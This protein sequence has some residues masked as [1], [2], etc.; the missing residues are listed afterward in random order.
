MLTVM[1]RV[2]RFQRRPDV[3]K[4]PKQGKGEKMRPVSIT[5]VAEFP[6]MCEALRAVVRHRQDFTVDEWALVG[7]WVERGVEF[8][9]LNLPEPKGG[10]GS[11]LADP[12]SRPPI[13]DVHGLAA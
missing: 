11:R 1:R 10:G 4:P 7:C 13:Q 6:T 3:R 8:M 9:E 2:H 12:R 5:A